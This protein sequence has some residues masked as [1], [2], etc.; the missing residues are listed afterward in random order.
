[1]RCCIQCRAIGSVCA[2]VFWSAKSPTRYPDTV[3][4]VS[5]LRAPAFVDF[6][7]RISNVLCSYQKHHCIQIQVQLK[8]LY[9]F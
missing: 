8:I 3:I 9:R 1:M 5:S 2:Y 6:Q 4:Y 7:V